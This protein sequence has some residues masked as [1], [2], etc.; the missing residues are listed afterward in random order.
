MFTAQLSTGFLKAG[1]S[2]DAGPWETYGR[3]FQSSMTLDAELPQVGIAAS[4][5]RAH[6]HDRM[7]KFKNFCGMASLPASQA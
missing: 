3:S 4:T 6:D 2:P 5:T 1:F 7:Q